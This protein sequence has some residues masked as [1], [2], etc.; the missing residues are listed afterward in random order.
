MANLSYRCGNKKKAHAAMISRM[1]RDIGRLTTL[2]EPL[3]MVFIGGIVGVILIA[4]YM[5][6][7]EIAGHVQAE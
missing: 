4:M 1:D 5:P 6:I 3:M 7:F 2:L